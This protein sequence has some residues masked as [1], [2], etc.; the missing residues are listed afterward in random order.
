MLQAQKYIEI[1]RSRG[2]R[3]LPLNRMYRLIRQ[4]DL[5]LAAYGK[6]YANKGAM[7]PGINPEDT[8]DGM[9][10]KRID[11]II[12]K[13]AAGTYQWTPVQRTY[14][15]KKK[16]GQRPLGKPGW[17]DKLLQEV[18]R[19]VLEA[20]YE[21]Q[22]S[23]SSHG[24][25]PGRGCHTALEAI[26]QHWKGVTW[27]IEGD[28]EGCYNNLDHELLLDLIGKDIHDQRFLKL[29]KGMLKAGYLENWTYHQTYSGVPQGGVA[30]PVLSNI[31]LDKLDKFVE[32]ELVPQY[33]KGKRRQ[34]N[35]EYRRLSR[36][37]TKAR[38]T[39]N[40]ETYRQLDKQRRAIP[41]GKPNDNNFRR[42]RYIRYADD[43]ALGFIG[44]QS[45]A[46]AIKAKIS[47]FLGTIQLTLSTSKTL[48]TH[49]V[50]GRA[51]FLG[52]D[53][54]VARNNH[55]ITQNQ[56]A[57]KKKTR[58]ANGKVVL[59]VPQEVA[60]QWRT[61]YTRKG[62][63]IHR[64]ELLNH[65]DY[66]IVTR[67]NI[68]CQGLLNYYILAQNVHKRLA[69]VRYAYL[70]SLVKTIAA[71]H[72]KKSSW[73]YRRYIGKLE[74]GRKVIRV[75]I[76]REKPKKPLIATFG[77][78]PICYA[79]KAML[80]DEIPRPHFTRTELVQRL[81]ANKC[82]LC[83]SIQNIEVH[84]V[85]KLANIKRKYKGQRQPPDWVIFMI[86]RNR[87]TVVVCR[88]CHHKIHRGAYDGSKLN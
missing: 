46:V 42:L 21:P 73:V 30:S 29:I 22:F 81:L 67:F 62:N 1:V 38:Q 60:N 78:K 12:A 35:P 40:L 70:Q 23:N 61:R 41:S 17:D 72:K 9:S 79:K 57:N 49:A 88:E 39:Q 44:P 15:D 31:I 69:P 24:F 32:G 68:E 18:I 80:K 6:L 64:A 53:I 86:S 71:K 87:K 8:V 5:F 36:K 58:A 55:R 59:S 20:Y 13:L 82:E 56:T 11:K 2:E 75:V 16:G 54:H 43:F 45:E 66:E 27:I 52:Y 26:R 83:E 4:R 84:H 48:I 37:M 19:M 47:A 25:R 10:L 76:P 3:K 28:I 65:S 33:T 77:A 63:P 34:R 14:I 7:T 51:R 85:H 50:E 74:D